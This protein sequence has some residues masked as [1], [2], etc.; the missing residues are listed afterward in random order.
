MSTYS[1]L[2]VSD[3]F[4]GSD[5]SLAGLQTAEGGPLWAPNDP[6]HLS[7]NA[8]NELGAAVV[9]AG[10][11]T[12]TTRPSKRPRLES[13][14]PAHPSGRGGR[15]FRGNAVAPL[16]VTGLAGPGFGR[17]R[18]NRRGSGTVYRPGW[19]RRGYGG[20]RGGFTGGRALRPQWGRRH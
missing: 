13:I 9:A 8:Y 6:V 18:D 19:G 11:D 2:R 10:G 17:G 3:I 12:E 7:R 1:I 14:V 20:R 16:W 15:G 4:A 5:S